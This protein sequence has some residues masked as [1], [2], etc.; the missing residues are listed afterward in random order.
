VP[1]K[2]ELDSECL[3]FDVFP[4]RRFDFAAKLQ[5]EKLPGYLQDAEYLFVAGF[6]FVKNFLFCN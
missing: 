2:A 5:T 4:E 3:Y 6:N 1:K